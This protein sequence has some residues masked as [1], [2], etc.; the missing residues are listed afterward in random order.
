MAGSTKPPATTSTCT[1]QPST[2]PARGA[3]ARPPRAGTTRR[4]PPADDE[5]R[6]RVASVSV[7]A[8]TIASATTSASNDEHRPGTASA[9]RRRSRL[10]AAREQQPARSRRRSRPSR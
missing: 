9:P 1:A 7:T 4:E 8:G 10:G 2:Y 5:R 6:Y 3:R